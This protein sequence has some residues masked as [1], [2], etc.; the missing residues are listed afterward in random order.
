[1]LTISAL[2]YAALGGP[3]RTLLGLFL[4][5]GIDRRQEMDE[6]IGAVN[7]GDR[8]GIEVASIAICYSAKATDP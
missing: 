2:T 6:L 3:T 7:R 4:L 8:V 1:M 5:L